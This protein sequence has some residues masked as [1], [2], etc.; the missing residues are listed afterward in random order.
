LNQALADVIAANR[1]EMLDDNL[2]RGYGTWGSGVRL[3]GGQ[4]LSQAMSA[5]QQT[6]CEPF[7]LHSMHA[8]FMRPGDPARAVIYD[9]DIIREGKSFVTRR[10]VARQHGAAIFSCQLSYQKPEPGF[11]HQSSM[12]QVVGPEGLATDDEL[13]SAAL[14]DGRTPPESRLA[15]GW[16]IEY[17]QLDPVNLVNPGRHSANCE[18]WFRAAEEIDGDLALHQQLLAFA[19]DHNILITALRPHGVSFTSPGMQI[20]TLDHAIWFHR[21]FRIDDWLL[22]AIESP[23]ACNA[24]GLGLGRIYDRAGVLVASV[25]QEGLIRQR[26]V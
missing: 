8:Y 7:V 25:S 6:V 22:Y 3:Y 21:P 19:S 26:P 17:R 9:V 18:I 1:L 13:V 14:F 20:A 23:S 24:R 12:P 15:P 4:V 11:D 16:P 10:V 5:A 2:F